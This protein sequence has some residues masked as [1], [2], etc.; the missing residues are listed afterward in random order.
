[1]EEE[2]FSS[3][4]HYCSFNYS[5]IIL[6]PRWVCEIMSKV[7]LRVCHS[8]HNSRAFPTL[9]HSYRPWHTCAL[10]TE[11]GVGGMNEWSIDYP[12][13]SFLGAVKRRHSK[14]VAPPLSGNH[15]NN[16]SSCDNWKLFLFLGLLFSLVF[17][18]AV[19]TRP[20]SILFVNAQFITRWFGVFCY[21]ATMSRKRLPFQ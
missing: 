19:P 16:C 9:W 20:G 8:C 3:I 17:H 5:C 7:L 4:G 10:I 12:P 14:R 13:P 2:M 11:R 21:L 1:M 6:K 15:L 18:P